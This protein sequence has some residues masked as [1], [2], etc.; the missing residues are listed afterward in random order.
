M[1]YLTTYP[2][3]GINKEI[4]FPANDP[5][6]FNEVYLRFF[7]T[8]YLTYFLL[9]NTSTPVFIPQTIV[10]GRTVFNKTVFDT[11]LNRWLLDY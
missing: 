7:L 9:M 1:I 3:L 10:D 11:Y 8:D 2:P 5:I 4:P 6:K